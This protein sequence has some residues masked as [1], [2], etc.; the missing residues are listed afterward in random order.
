MKIHTAGTIGKPYIIMLAGSFCTSGSLKYLYDKLTDNYCIIL[1]E[2]NGHYENSTFTTR[3]NE[4]K[5]IADYIKS[6]NISQ[7]K[8][9]YGQSMGA[10]VGIELL[11]QLTDNDIDVEHCFFDG[12]PCIKLSSLYKK[13]M[14]L[15]FKT[16]VNMMKKKDVDQV[17]NMKLLNKLANGDKESLRPMIEALSKGAAF[18]TNETVKNETE[19]CYTFDFPV[20]DEFTQRK[21]HF[22]YAKN[23]KA[24]K[25]C[26][27]GVK[28]A[29]PMAEYTAVDGYGHLTYSIK[30]TDDYIKM[31]RSIC[32]DHVNCSE[33]RL[34]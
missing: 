29:Y 13:L 26:F 3:Q 20:F 6:Q 21:M 2:Y 9:I 8:M 25:S 28:K 16:M 12:A 30:N 17:M 31:I 33:Q 19:C 1:P 24:Y 11:K 5:E 18:F 7:I 14:Y 22:F 34:R 32:E 23:E 10:E 4:A 27:D 15:K